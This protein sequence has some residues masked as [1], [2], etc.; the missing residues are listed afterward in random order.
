MQKRTTLRSFT[1]EISFNPVHENSL[2]PRVV[3]ASL[4]SSCVQI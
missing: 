2:F 4:F 1:A 3:T